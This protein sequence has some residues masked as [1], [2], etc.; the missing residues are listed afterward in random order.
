M[1]LT[2]YGI[3]CGSLKLSA[4]YYQPEIEPRSPF[5]IYSHGFTSCKHSMDGLAS[6]LALKGYPGITYDAPGHKLGGSGGELNSIDE[7]VKSCGAVA[8]FARCEFGDKSLV[9]A[10]HSMGAMASIEQASRQYS[11]G[12]QVAGVVS[13]ALGSESARGFSSTVGQAMLRQR[14][15]YIAGASAADLIQQL[16]HW[17]GYPPQLAGLQ[18]LFIAAKN[19]VLIKAERVQA[20]AE[21]CGSKDE[22]TIVDSSH[23][24]APDRSRA[25]IYEWLLNL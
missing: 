4:L 21:L 8:E 7:W 18:M 11:E 14:E 16:D 25:K 1:K 22:I 5:L 12:K 6:Y 3:P 2:N 24:D 23:L 17:S 15:D 20:L 10:G 19:D 13:I 9:F